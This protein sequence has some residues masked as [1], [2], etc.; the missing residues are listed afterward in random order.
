MTS[1]NGNNF[2]VT[3]HLCGEFNGP[4]W[5]PRTKASDAEF[6][7]FF[8]LRL[9]KRLSKQ[10]WGW[11]FETLSHPSWLHRNVHLVKA[12]SP[13]TLSVW[14]HDKNHHDA[15]M[16]HQGEAWQCLWTFELKVL[17]WFCST[18]LVDLHHSPSAVLHISQDIWLACECCASRWHSACWWRD[19]RPRVLAY[20]VH[21]CIW[22]VQSMTPSVKKYTN[23]VTGVGLFVK[24]HLRFMNYIF[25]PKEITLV[26]YS[27]WYQHFC[28]AWIN[29]ETFIIIIFTPKGT[30]YLK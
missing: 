16:R 28:K 6:D 26:Y 9:N 18:Q 29:G 20:W 23:M 5:I 19:Q 13:G 3:G 4:R 11:W 15:L 12:P 14:H 17:L 21:V 7:V 27:E 10:S 30:S 1:T 24:A 8:D 22:S 2:R 25:F